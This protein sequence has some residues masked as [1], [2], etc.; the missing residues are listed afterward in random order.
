MVV[1]HKPSRNLIKTVLVHSHAVSVCAIPVVHVFHVFGLIVFPH[2]TCTPPT[3][4]PSFAHVVLSITL[5]LLVPVALVLIVKFPH[6]GA[7]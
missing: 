6:T 4:A 2:A 5:V 3:H 1:F 7:V